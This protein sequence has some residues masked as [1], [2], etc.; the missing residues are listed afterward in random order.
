MAISS[1]G[2]GSGLPLDELLKNLR[3]S[4]NQSLAL[5]ESR[6][7]TVQSRL[8]G[9]G[10]IK[11]SIEAL[12]TAA[13]A[14]G[15]AETFGAVKTSGGGDFF[16]ATGSSKA[17]A[18]QYNIA[19]TQLATR[20]TLTSAGHASSTA[21]E[22]MSPTVD[23]NFQIGAET[24][25]LTL[26]KDDTSLAGIVKAINNDSSLGFSATLVNN[27]SV[28]H[29]LLTTNKTG[30]DAAITKIEVVGSA[31]LQE[32]L[33]F[34]SPGT[35]ATDPLIEEAAKNAALEINKIQINSQ[36]NTIE[37][38]IDGIT[39]TLTK[40]HSFSIDTIDPAKRIYATDAL[41]VS[42]DDTVASKA[43][44]TFV[45]AY[46][47]LQ[48]IIKTLTAY[49]VD[50]QTSSQLTGDNLARNVQNQMRNALN[51]ASSSGAFASLSQLGITTNPSD[52]TLK[53]DDTK[54]AAALKDNLVDVQSLLAGENGIS[55]QMSNAADTFV[56]SG[57]LIS[58]A[59]DSMSTTLKN[60]EKQYTAESGRIDA[61]M[62]NYRKQFSALD[63]MMAQM[64]SVSSYL[65]QQ[66]SML[67]NLNEKK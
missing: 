23:I 61:K 1:I 46:N 7:K 26:D 51:V 2:V 30:T 25:K 63:S 40:T 4:E 35:S 38:A 10:T 49:N 9:Y 17:I 62:E 11:S 33:G 65:T 60:L 6:A 3:T 55:K 22:T 39:L 8:S 28:S 13:T 18:G 14:L 50:N 24:K 58:T 37:N 34:N 57:G 47:N 16:T 66:L 45:S 31:K 53:I 41:T 19:V 27:G 59:T 29:L 20:Q 21:L 32:T 43:V 5:I 67:G 54:L 12:K 52:G 44:N 15:K 56:K 64:N 42:R 48:N 36:T